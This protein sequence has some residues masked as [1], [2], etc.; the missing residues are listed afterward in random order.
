MPDVPLAAIIELHRRVVRN[1]TSKF[2]P[3]LGDYRTA[4][5]EWDYWA[6]VNSNPDDKTPVRGALPAPP[7]D[8]DGPGAQALLALGA[9]LRAGHGRVDC[10]CGNAARLDQQSC[11]WVCPTAHCG[12]N[13]PVAQMIAALHAEGISLAGNQDDESVVLPDAKGK[14]PKP[15]APGQPQAS[16]AAPKPRELTAL[17]VAADACNVDMFALEPIQLARFSAF[18][19][20]WNGKYTLPLNRQYLDEYYPQYI[21]EKHP[22]EI[23]DDVL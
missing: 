22:E 3:T 14:K 9:W 19:K 16:N 23:F 12:F 13:L 8:T 10:K 5:E 20:W 21:E 2:P 1:W 7:P 11:N 15:S 6:E 17:E 18:V 4:W